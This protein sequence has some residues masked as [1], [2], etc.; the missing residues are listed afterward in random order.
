[1][2]KIQDVEEKYVFHYKRRNKFTQTEVDRAHSEI[3][4]ELISIR[5]YILVYI[6]RAC[7]LDQSRKMHSHLYLAG[8]RRNFKHWEPHERFQDLHA[9]HSDRRQTE[10]SKRTQ[11]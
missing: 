3:N 4:Y 5:I 9:E 8:G 7:T 2:L 1:M 6:G 10:I 11:N